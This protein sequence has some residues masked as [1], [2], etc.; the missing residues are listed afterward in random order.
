VTYTPPKPRFGRVSSIFCS[1][2]CPRCSASL[3]ACRADPCGRKWIDPPTTAMHIE[4][5][6]Q[7]WIHHK[8]YREHYKF[9]PLNQISPVLQHAVVAAEDARFYQHHGFDWQELEIAAKGDMEGERTRG[10]S[11]SR[12]NW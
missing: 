9:I 11:P 10:A 4:R 7:A 1:M 2:D 12:S 6:L 8:P 3:V 5:R